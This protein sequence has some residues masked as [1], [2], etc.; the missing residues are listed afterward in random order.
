MRRQSLLTNR[1]ILGMLVFFIAVAFWVFRIREQYQPLYKEGVVD[2]QQGQ[3]SDALEKFTRAYTISPNSPDVILMMGWTNLKLRRLEE[4]GYYFNRA[5][6]IDPK[7]EEARLG[8]G[9]VA[10]ETGRG[11]LDLDVLKA[12]MGKRG[13]DPGVRLLVAGAYVRVGRNLEAAAIYK[14]LQNDKDYGKAAHAAL[15]DMFGLQGFNDPIPDHLAA[16]SH[17]A[18]TQL[19]FRAG[20]GSLWQRA[21]GDWQKFYASGVNLGVAAPGYYPGAPPLAGGTYAT[22]LRWAQQLNANVVR[23]YGLMP[24]GFYRAFKHHVADGSKLTLYQQIVIDN[25][26]GNDL[27]DPNYVEGVKAEIR[28]VVDAVHGRAQVVPRPGRTGGVYESDLSAQVSGILFGRELDPEVVTQTN[29]GSSSKRSY[30]GTYISVSEAAPAQVWVAEMLDYLV[31]YETESYNWQH[32]VAFVNWPR[33]DPLYHPTESS[34]TN[35]TAID[36][37]KFR[38]KPGFQAGLFASY[39]IYLHYPEFFVLDPTYANARDKQGINPLAAYLRDLRAHIPYPLVVTEYGV[40]NAMG[41]LDYLPNNWNYGGHTEEEQAQ[42]LSRLTSTVRDSGCAGG[43]VFELLDEWYPFDR[44]Y[45]DFEDPR[46]R[47]TLWVNE[48]DPRKRYGLVGYRTSKWRLFAGNAAAWQK[49]AVLYRSGRSPAE[50]GLRS[51][52]AATDEAFLYF[53]L[54]ASCPDCRAPPGAPLAPEK[55]G[56]AVALSTAPSLVGIKKLPFGNLTLALGANFLLYLGDPA[57]GRLLVA[58]NYNPF[59]VA[60]DGKLEE[61]APLV[62]ELQEK[63]SFQA[64]EFPL[65]NPRT[66][67]GGVTYP[68]QRFNASVLRYGNG[69]PASND[70]DSLAEWYFDARSKAIL[71]RIPWGKLLV[72]D[73]SSRHV[74]YRF[75]D[76]GVLKSVPSSGMSVSVFALKGPR[77]GGGWSTMS[78][79]ES[80]PAAASG[81]IERPERFAWGTWDAV[82]PDIYLKKA[83]YEMQKDFSENNRPEAPL[84]GGRPGTRAGSG[85]ARDGRRTP[86]ASAPPVKRAAVDQRAEV[87]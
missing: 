87:R 8:A 17:P 62:P 33:L 23:V 4:A 14:S 50:A 67:R 15:N 79:T 34:R 11:T 21:G 86:V 24:P 59:G 43:V 27:Y 64:L 41:I 75:D 30:D 56:Y 74:F 78:V 12:L 60:P 65:H 9:F 26:P 36:E 66:G 68:E 69:D 28:Q 83:Y 48:L 76:S 54:E 72:T 7:T 19:R 47:A 1:V 35:A 45:A 32:P 38:V 20:E 44:L 63:G 82:H 29:L 53:R 52:Q 61:K 13:N 42:I 55:T 40:S 5:L 22:W 16:L 3:Y 18:Q 2:Y 85:P 46:E 39:H 77:A 70:Y 84:G 25:P 80:F 73:P 49:E 51:V 71:V 58:E 37:S 6:S 81:R 31:I 10:L 57:S